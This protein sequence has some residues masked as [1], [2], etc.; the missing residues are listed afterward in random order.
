MLTRVPAVLPLSMRAPLVAFEMMRSLA[1]KREAR[2][3]I[4]PMV[5]PVMELLRNV[6]LR[7]LT[8][9]TP[10]DWVALIRIV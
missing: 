5:D 6:V 2:L 9:I 8:T 7:E 4:R 3:N 10:V 1:K